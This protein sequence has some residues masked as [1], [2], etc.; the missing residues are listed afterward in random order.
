[1]PI[2]TI[3]SKTEEKSLYSLQE[4]SFKEKEYFFQIPTTL[5]DKVLSYELNKGKIAFILMYGYFK[6]S[7]QFYDAS[8]YPLCQRSCPNL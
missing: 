7:H 6:A 8:E 1:M 3:L 4:L 2:I 5:L